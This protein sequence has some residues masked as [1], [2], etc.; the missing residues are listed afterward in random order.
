MTP[1]QT[2]D[3]LS[4]LNTEEER[5]YWQMTLFFASTGFRGVEGFGVK[6]SDIDYDKGQIALNRGFSKGAETKGKVRKQMK[7][8]AMTPLLGELL[9]EWRQESPYNRDTDWVFASPKSRGLVPYSA[10]TAAAK[11]LKPA[12]IKAGVIP[13]DYKGKFGWHNL[14]HSLG[15]YYGT[16]CGMSLKE[17]M[18][19]LRHNKTETAAIYVHAGQG[20]LRSAQSSYLEAVHAESFKGKEPGELPVGKP[21]V[22]KRCLAVTL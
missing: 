3:V 1:E 19:A 10:S 5:P 7:P 6:W 21:V 9:K 20:N 8:S 14:R 11:H 18:E 22:I 16:T 2:F 4:I 15:T 12:A 13:A 17:V